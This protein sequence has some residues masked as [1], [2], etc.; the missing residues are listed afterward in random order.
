MLK[1]FQSPVLRLPINYHKSPLQIQKYSDTVSFQSQRGSVSRFDKSNLLKADSLFHHPTEPTAW[2]PC[3]GSCRFRRTP[4]ARVARAPAARNPGSRPAPPATVRRTPQSMSCNTAKGEKRWLLQPRKP[5]DSPSR[6]ARTLTSIKSLQ[7]GPSRGARR[8]KS[9][10]SPRGIAPPRFGKKASASATSRRHPGARDM[11]LPL[12]PGDAMSI[13]Q[14]VGRS[15]TC[16]VCS[17]TLAS[18]GCDM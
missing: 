12:E 3:H 16:R 7:P 10:S 9:S 17:V 14:G 18:G 4:A 13:T 1:S 15:A 11:T 5:D 8:S 2:S 6:G